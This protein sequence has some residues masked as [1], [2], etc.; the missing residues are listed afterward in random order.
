M[1]TQGEP[2]SDQQRLLQVM[3]DPDLPPAERADAGRQIN[4]Y[5]DPRSGVG[6][7]ADGLPDI[8][9]C[10]IPAGEAIIGGNLYEFEKPVR[11]LTLSSFYIAKYPLTYKQFQTFL[12]AEDGFVADRW[13]QGL[14]KRETQPFEQRW[15]FDNH[16]R[17]CVS[18]Y[19]SVAFTRW[20]SAKLGYSVSLPSE[21]QWEKAAR[22]VDGRAYP[23]GDDYRSGSANI[24]ETKDN[25]GSYALLQTSAVG[26][27]P[28]GVSPYG[29]LDM[30]G[31]VW[32]W[33]L[34][35]YEARS[36]EDLGSANARVLHG[37]AWCDQHISARVGI[38]HVAD[39]EYRFE[40]SGLRLVS[41][42]PKL[43]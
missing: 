8:A 42:R 22:G 30:A 11:R 2:T 27:Y 19:D 15:K 31:N 1:H 41:N 37:G 4:Q 7:R 32:E 39:S 10:E 5:G 36:S 13:W 3:L 6:L 40:D 18:W 24:D 35:D 33:C 25:I 16:P 26:I 29:V 9:W 43:E 20:L 12:D 17:E 14:A 34:D 23:W 21:A 28:Q 38:P